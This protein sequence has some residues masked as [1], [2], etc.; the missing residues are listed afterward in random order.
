MFR[1]PQTFFFASWGLFGPSRT[2]GM[3]LGLMMFSLVP[4]LASGAK[5]MK[6]SQP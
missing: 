3:S 2:V 6:A 5:D 1:W 4:S